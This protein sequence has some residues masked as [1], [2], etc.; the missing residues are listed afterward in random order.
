LLSLHLDAQFWRERE[1]ERERERQRERER[2][3]E[4][5]SEPGMVTFIK[6]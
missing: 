1:R 3:R 2:E 6:V 4:R 5:A